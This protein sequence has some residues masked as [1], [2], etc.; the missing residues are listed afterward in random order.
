LG[1]NNEKIFESYAQ[2]STPEAYRIFWYYG[3]GKNII[4]II[5][6]MPHP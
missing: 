1:P 6:I 2:Q 4:S 5:A 3:P